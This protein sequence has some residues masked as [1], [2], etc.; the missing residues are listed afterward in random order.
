MHVYTIS[1]ARVSVLVQN[2]AVI[3]CCLVIYVVLEYKT[4]IVDNHGNS[5][6]LAIYAVIIVIALTSNLVNMARTT[7]I[8]RDWIVEMCNGDKDMLAGK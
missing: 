8:E 4:S 5:L 7:A 6:L 1:V 2:L 3:L